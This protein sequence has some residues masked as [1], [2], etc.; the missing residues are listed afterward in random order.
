MFNFDYQSF[1]KTRTYKINNMKKFKY[2]CVV[3]TNKA[4]IYIERL[5]QCGYQTL[6]CYTYT[7]NTIVALPNG[8]ILPTLIKN[9]LISFSENDYDCLENV[10]DCGVDTNL[11]LT[12]AAMN[13]IN[14]YWQMFVNVKSGKQIICTQL[15]LSNYVTIGELLKT[16]MLLEVEFRQLTCSQVITKIN[17]YLKQYF[18]K[19]TKEEINNIWKNYNKKYKINLLIL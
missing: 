5:K 10:I 8:I 16:D 19:A 15:D 1:Y 9:D 17:Q 6:S 12:L 2:S 11:F 14:D 7:T 18:R 4:S 13:D 3:R